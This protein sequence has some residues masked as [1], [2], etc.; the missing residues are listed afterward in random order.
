V[1]LELSFRPV[2]AD[3]PDDV[4]ELRPTM[5]RAARFGVTARLSLGLVSALMAGACYAGTLSAPAGEAFTGLWRLVAI[6]AVVSALFAALFLPLF[7]A[8]LVAPIRLLTLATRSVG[9][10]DLDTHLPV[11]ARDE[12]GELTASFNTMVAGLRERTDLRA[13][14]VDL[15]GELRASRERIVAAGDLARRRVERDLHDGAQQ[16][17]VTARLKVGLLRRHLEAGDD[18]S[19]MIADLDNEIS[20]ALAELRELAHGIYPMQLDQD[21]LRGALSFA[22]SQAAVPAR[23]ACDG[24]E[25]YR[26]E[27]EAAVYFSCLEALQNVAKHAGSASTAEVALRQIDGILHFS[28]RDDGVGFEPGEQQARSGLQNVSDRIGALGGL[29]RVSSKKGTG[30]CLSGE[31][32]VEVAA[33]T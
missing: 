1:W 26:P 25:R 31:I 4:A 5:R 17:L 10:G 7:S 15:I 2:L 9:A 33:L 27:L 16:R 12:L 32:P 21:G 29:V 11:T 14:N 22:V 3:L 8:L 6:T 20:R 23:L 24:I 13:R 19:T 28:V 18:V 30:T